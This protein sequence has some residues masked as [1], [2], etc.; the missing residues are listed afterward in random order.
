[1]PPKNVNQR[2]FASEA[3][4]FCIASLRAASQ[5]E[6]GVV[7]REVAVGLPSLKSETVNGTFVTVKMQFLS[8]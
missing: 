8:N 2:H 7:T 6:A 4:F 1:M 5:T 3:Q